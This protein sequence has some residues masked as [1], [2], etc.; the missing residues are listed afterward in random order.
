MITVLLVDDHPIFLRTLCSLV[1]KASDMQ[2]VATVSN[3]EDA[4]AQAVLY[5]PDVIV[6]DIS[7]PAI[8]GIEAT[9][10]IY[11]NC[12]STRV[13]I[14]SGYNFAGYVH[15]AL[16]AGAFGYVLKDELAQDLLVAIRTV[17]TG[18]RY[19]SKQIAGFVEQYAR[20]NRNE[21]LPS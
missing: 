12:Q 18:N 15:R 14:L 13:L 6:M 9:K 3:A 16:Q 19:F 10:Q 5:C 7:M 20:Q 21:S 1:T 2:V 17:Y 8:D 11:A 4:V